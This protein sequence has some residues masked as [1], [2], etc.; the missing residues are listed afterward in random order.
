MRICGLCAQDGSKKG[1]TTRYLSAVQAATNTVSSWLQKGDSLDAD[2][3]EGV[4]SPVAA[5][6]AQLRDEQQRPIRK[7]TEVRPAT[8]LQLPHIL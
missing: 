8:L 4:P 5:A 1:Y 6:A 3:S 7:T 2:G